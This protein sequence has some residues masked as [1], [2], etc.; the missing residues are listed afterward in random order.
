[1]ESSAE[2]ALRLQQ[3]VKCRLERHTSADIDVQP[4]SPQRAAWASPTKW[5][6]ENKDEREIR[7]HDE[8]RN[9]MKR[10]LFGIDEP[11]DDD[12]ILGTSRES[13]EMVV[14][15]TLVPKDQ[16]CKAHEKPSISHEKEGHGWAFGEQLDAAISRQF[17]AGVKVF[18]PDAIFQYRGGGAD[19]DRVSLSGI[20]QRDSLSYK[21]RYSTGEWTADGLGIEEE[22]IY[23]RGVHGS[24]R[25]E[26][27]FLTAGSE[28]MGE[29]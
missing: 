25:A 9:R 18:D 17:D 7:L 11:A 14:S 1:M 6:V 19:G 26:D 10:S 21:K 16:P 29:L 4:F 2:R 3:E 15:T 27:F 23:K 20:F 13:Q 8:V 22:L 28:T 5:S 12:P 24:E